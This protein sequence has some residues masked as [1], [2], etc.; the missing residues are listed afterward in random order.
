MRL[1]RLKS[2]GWW[3]LFASSCLL[4]LTVLVTWL[5]LRQPWLGI[6]FLPN[7]EKNIITVKG[8]PYL[9]EG[10][11]SDSA[12]VAFEKKGLPTFAIQPIDLIE[13]PDTL[14]D[15]ATYRSF[16]ARQA[17]LAHYIDGQPLTLILTDPQGQVYRYTNTP[18]KNRPLTSLPTAFWIQLLAGAVGFLVGLWVLVL[19]PKDS[20]ARCFAL[21]GVGL[22]L[23]AFAAAIYSVRELFIPADLFQTLGILN[24]I[25]AALFG[26]ALMALF[27]VFPSKLISPKKL[28]IIPAI[29]G[30]WLLCDVL[31][32]IS[33]PA[34]GMYLPV[35]LQTLA[36]LIFI[37][38]Q[39][40]KNRGNPLDIAALRWLGLSS[41]LTSS[42]FLFFAAIPALL[43][44]PTI[45][46]QG[47][48]FG[49]FLILYAGLALGLRR[50][51]LF[52]LDRWA[53]H[54]LLWVSGAITLLLLDI[55]MVALLHLNHSLSLTLSLLISGFLWLPFRVWLWQRI[56]H[57]NNQNPHQDFRRI[58]HI[59]LSPDDNQRQLRWQQFLS[60]TFSPLHLQ[61]NAQPLSLSSIEPQLSEN[62]LIFSVPAIGKISP[63]TMSHA[64]QGQRLFTPH[65]E[66]YLS[67]IIEM[68]HHANESRDAYNKGAREERR[69]IARDLHD[70]IGSR[71]LTGLHQSNIDNTRHSIR[72]AISE[73][74]V[75]INGLTGTEV[76]FDTLL[77]EL[78]HETR[79]RLE[80]ANIVLDWPLQEEKDITLGY[81]AYRHYLSVMRELVSNI[82]RHAKANQ[83]RVTVDYQQ[84]SIITHVEDN[85]IGLQTPDG[86]RH[87]LTNLHERMAALH[88]EIRFK[89]TS[90]Y[91]TGTCITLIMPE[92]TSAP[93]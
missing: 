65:D 19:K 76:L 12:L 77:A 55:A 79:Q 93:I 45:L 62:G 25:G 22:M 54:L 35:L 72:Q 69:R 41:L 44:I 82:L 9:P 50:Y 6:T 91:A 81:P 1:F 61:P 67:D 18:H 8:N 37:A 28:I 88:G 21:T 15:Y 52:D 42:F 16:L 78:R 33:T 71:L 59:S 48:A 83:V 47:H 80:A 13:D 43:E 17:T 11:L 89:T 75:I 46:S 90:A 3:L 56:V 38:L 64:H 49:L 74:R 23:S 20:G 58:L 57:R 5:T 30:P 26:C 70:D 84:G 85:G 66:K 92:S 29:F 32:L 4:I 10:I 2:P 24:H 36:I 63:F 51:R 39:W 68:L 31:H 53:F 60:D 14:P 27:L 40:W 73:M 87:G 7:P 34:I 86:D